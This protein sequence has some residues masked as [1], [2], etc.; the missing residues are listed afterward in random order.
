MICEYFARIRAVLGQIFPSPVDI[1]VRSGTVTVKVGC[2][3]AIYISN[4][5]GLPMNLVRISLIAAAMLALTSRA[6]AGVLYAATSAGTTG[7]LYILDQTNGAVI[8]D[9][10]PLNDVAGLNYP[11]T[12]LAFNPF[13][14]TLFGS[15]GN[16]QSAT[17]ARLVTIDAATAQVT[18]V[19][20]F[21]AGPVN[22]SG[23]PA[24]MADIAF[25]PAGNLYGVGSIG[26]PNV[27]SINTATGQ[28]TVVG[29]SGFSSTSGGGLAISPAGTFFG[30]P[31][32][33]NF[34]TYNSG[35]GAFTN[36]ANP[37]EPAGGAW[38]ALAFDGNV[39]YGL[40]LG[41]GSPPPTH[42]VI[43]NT[44]TGGITDLGASVNSLDAIAFRPVPEP[45]T[46]LLFV[47]GALSLGFRR[48]KR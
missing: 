33:S 5:G 48:I 26:G 45:A 25:D 20:S 12:G 18:V 16:S 7:E 15:S 32:A 1:V 9:V 13:T 31:N 40:N 3:G 36:I 44:A 43:Y 2:T 42:L 11:I 4:C 22:G 46:A 10:G 23:A 8:Q 37:V 39:L 17:Q 41:S 30:S 6:D 19:G 21:N 27:Y 47:M 29:P 28:A 34:G 38:G 35:T 24:T 14:G